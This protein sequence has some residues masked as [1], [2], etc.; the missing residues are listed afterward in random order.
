[1]F[2]FDFNNYCDTL[3]SEF[4]IERK[5]RTVSKTDKR[6]VQELK[7]RIR[8]EKDPQ[9]KKIKRNLL[10]LYRRG[11]FEEGGQCSLIIKR[12]KVHQTKEQLADNSWLCPKCRKTLGQLLAEGKVINVQ[13]YDQCVDCHADI[14]SYGEVF[15]RKITKKDWKRIA[16]QTS[17]LVG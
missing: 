12:P 17:A 9:L 16:R 1:M 7:R 5:V 3:K 8:E 4:F 15:P 11:F 10:A 2:L 13:G 14:Q 6:F